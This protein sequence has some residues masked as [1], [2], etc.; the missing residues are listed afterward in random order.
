[1]SIKISTANPRYFE[2]NGKTIFLAGS[3]TW[4]N[5]QPWSTYPQSVNEHI[6]VLKANNHNYVR[7]WVC[8]SLVIPWGDVVNANRPTKMPYMRTG[9]EPAVDGEPKLDLTRFDESFFVD[10]HNRA[11][12]YCDAGMYVSVMFDW[13]TM[14][15]KTMDTGRYADIKNI[16]NNVSG[17][18]GTDTNSFVLE[19]MPDNIKEL[20]TNFVKK[21]ISTLGDL[22][23]VFW[24]IGNELHEGS[25]SYQSWML[26]VV[27]SAENEYGVTP[28]PI[29]ITAIQGG[30]GTVTGDNVVNDGL[31]ASGADWI[32]PRCTVS[33]YTENT[34][35]Y[36]PPMNNG[37]KVIL[38]DTD[39]LGTLNLPKNKIPQLYRQ[40]VWKSFTRGLNITLM[41]DPWSTWDVPQIHN[42]QN[43]RNYVGDVRRYAARLDLANTT[44]STT[45][46]STKYCLIGDGQYLIYQPAET[47]ASF[48]VNV[49]AGEYDYEWFDPTD[50]TVSDSG[51]M[52]VSP[53][54]EFY[55]DRDMVLLL[56]EGEG[57]GTTIPD[58]IPQTEWTLKHVDSEE[59]NEEY[60][61]AT[62]AFD[63]DRNTFWHTEWGADEPDHPHEIQIDLG[64]IY[65]ID[66]FRYLPRQDMSNGRIKDYQ[67]YVSMDGYKWGTPI[68]GRFNTD[69]TEKE[70]PF[71][72]KTGRYIRLVALNEIKG[73]AWTTVAELNVI[74]T[75]ST[76]PPPEPHDIR[77]VIPKG[78]E[79]RIDGTRIDATT[80]ARMLNVLKDFIK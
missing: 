2:D 12:A 41:D 29:G 69:T 8:T 62:H 45:V 14:P 25:M 67:F 31:F 66:G 78:A 9:T 21:V 71:T 11:K 50:R 6:A 32:S 33:G 63:G 53:S 15:Y 51:T 52:A 27:K 74:G 65:D 4:Y 59:L 36:D 79:L 17:I 73:K 60:R 7:G 20:H 58:T 24:E 3:H 46:C 47:G 30:W 49:A 40:W 75:E 19:N 68:S 77:I 70:V 28:R 76:T 10:M 35:S 39:H 38:S 72:T 55:T 44:P 26:G 42:L 37:Q 61:P 1:M 16:D 23:N 80:I 56:T 57:N 18:A 43:G 64:R 54:T 34:Y 5:L 13:D 22:S 48:T